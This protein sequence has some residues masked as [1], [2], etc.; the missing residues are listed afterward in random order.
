M[1]EQT[2]IEARGQRRLRGVREP[3]VIR[4]R[5]AL[6][7]RGGE[8]SWSELDGLSSS[9][10]EGG[11][12]RPSDSHLPGRK[13]VTERGVL[14]HRVQGRMDLKLGPWGF[15]TSALFFRDLP[16]GC[17]AGTGPKRSPQKDEHHRGMLSVRKA[18]AL[19]CFLGG[20]SG[21]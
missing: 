9:E 4:K 13:T 10:C 17:V 11:W 16:S 6:G 19:S 15:K 1:T 12:D 2:G 18:N 7:S 20:R 21:R 14:A 3:R 5:A 8:T